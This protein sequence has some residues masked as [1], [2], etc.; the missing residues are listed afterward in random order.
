[1]L[2]KIVDEGVIPDTVEH[3]R[4]V[5]HKNIKKEKEF[6]PET[7]KRFKRFRVVGEGGKKKVAFMRLILATWLP[8]L[9]YMANR[10]FGIWHKACN[11]S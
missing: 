3:V 11:R 9:I 10:H 1:M 6:V 2:M 7:N 4:H 5:N 8:R